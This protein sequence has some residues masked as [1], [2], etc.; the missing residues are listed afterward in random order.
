M[1]LSEAANSFSRLSGVYGLLSLQTLLDRVP[2]EVEHS[3]ADSVAEVRYGTYG[4]CA[5]N[6]AIPCEVRGA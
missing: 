4:R 2:S 5:S 3:P 1:K 6:V